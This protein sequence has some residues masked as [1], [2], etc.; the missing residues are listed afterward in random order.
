[1]SWPNQHRWLTVWSSAEV[2][3]TP[4]GWYERLTAAYSESHRHYHN[5]Q[6][7]A[8][9][10][11]ELDQA[12]RLA[13]QPAAV[14][15]ALWFHDAVYDPKAVDNE[16]RSAILANQC[17]VEANASDG[18]IKT[19]TN[20]VM[21][22]K[23]HVIDADADAGLMVDVDLSI[24]GKGEIRFL[25]YEKQI[26]DEYAWV[27]DSLYASK[28]AE[29]LERFLARPTLYATDWFRAK[30]EQSARHQLNS[31]IAKLKEILS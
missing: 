1:M 3:R 26:R 25:E 30:Y 6:H 10:L 29:I 23:A 22:T 31:S 7:I 27:P 20:L 8:E 21:A 24:F 12:Q 19:V 18:L 16:E 13:H 9:C 2:S 14:E 5:Q 28:R 15:I 11:A 17:L 4:V